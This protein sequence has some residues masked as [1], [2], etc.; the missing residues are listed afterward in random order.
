MNTMISPVLAAITLAAASSASSAST[1]R[2][3]FHVDPTAFLPWATP[4]L[5]AAPLVGYVLVLFSVR[6]RRGA[7]NV[8]QTVL[9][10][11][12]VA[13]LLIWWARFRQSGYYPYSL[14]WINIPVAFQG[15]QRF[16]G[17]GVDLSFRLD[18][19]ALAALVAML[20]ILVASVTWH[21]VAGRGEQGPVRFQVNAMLFALGAA[22]VVLS[23]D[24]VELL[25]FWL[26]TGVAT[27]LLLGHRWGTDEAGRRGAVALMVP[28]V[29]DAALLCAVGLVYSRFGTLTLDSLYPVLT[30]SVGVGL[31]SLT[32]VAVLAFVAVAARACVWPFTVWQTGTVDAPPA[33]VAMAAGVW[34]VLAGSLLLRMLPV[35]HAAGVQAPRIAEA[36]LGV[37]AV[38]GPLLALV[39]VDLRRSTVLASSGAVALALLGLLGPASAAV[40]LTAVLAVGAAR[41]AA[42]LAGASAANALRTVDLRVV[43]GGWQRMRLTSTALLV[44]AVVLALCGLESAMLWPRDLAWLAFAAGMALVAA[45]GYRVYLAVA[46]APLRRRRAFEPSRVEDPVSTV[47]GAALVCALLGIVAVALAFFTPWIAVVGAGGHAVTDMGTSVLWLIAPL[48]GAAAASI[49]FASRRD[50]ALALGARGGEV[51]AAV[52]ALAGGVYD[53]FLGRPGRGAVGAAEDVGIPAVESGVGRALMDT[54]GLAGLAERGLPWVPAVVGLA[55][56]L[57]VAFGLLSQG[58]QR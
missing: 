18:H 32:A 41:S 43:G 8:A 47:V 3:G 55:V 14:Q 27:Y 33:A 28:F 19:A 40:G 31:K 13:T 12:L 4:M 22:G 57:V 24:L 51:L 20:V 36:T 10:V 34:P 46:H 23:G 15:D 53:R 29:G 1:A 52:W 35:M 11:M 38:V 9:V 26:V 21:R 42:L 49:A 39:S 30:T 45:T 48:L 5:L 37:A 6:T 2:G 25:A 58:L 44:S 17:F 16:Q 56:V 7:A 54:G 50:Q